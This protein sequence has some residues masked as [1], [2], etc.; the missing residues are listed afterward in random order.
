MNLFRDLAFAR[1]NAA[2]RV[3]SVAEAANYDQKPWSLLYKAIIDSLGASPSSFQLLYPFASWNWP[4]QSVG[5]I[6]AAQYDFCST[7][8]QWSAVGAYVSSGDRFNQAYEQFLNVILPTTDDPI[9]REQIRVSGEALTNAT[10]DYT[11]AVTQAE[12][13]YRDT[14]GPSNTPPFTDWLGTLQG[15]GWQTKIVAAQTRMDQAQVNYNTVVAQANTPG[16]ENA[17]TQFKNLDFYSKLTNPGLSTFPKVPSWSVSQNPGAWVDA[18]KAGHGPAGATMGFT[19][20]DSSY[21]YSKTWAGGSLAVQ[22]FFWSVNV[23]G[24][25]ERITE[26]EMDQQ[27]EVSIEFEAVDQIQIQPT[28][29]Y[30][31]SFVRSMGGGPFIKGYSAYGA[32][33]DKAVFGEKGFIGLLKTGIFVGYKPTF[34]ITTSQSSFNSFVEKF[35]VCT[36]LRIGPFTMNAEGGSEKSGWSY[37]QAGRSFSGTSTSDSPLIIGVTVARLPN[38]VDGANALAE[39]EESE[40][41]GIGYRFE[42]LAGDVLG[43]GVT[44]AEAQAL[45]AR[46][47]KPL[48]RVLAGL[49]TRHAHDVR[50]LPMYGDPVLTDGI[51]SIDFNGPALT[52]LRAGIF[53]INKPIPHVGT[54]YVVTGVYDET[55]LPFKFTLTCR[56][57]GRPQSRFS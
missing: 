25:W 16:L 43:Q 1:R 46:S 51:A 39:E 19:N 38:Q 4:T 10:N 37:S 50:V 14:V 17:H 32:D 22:E 30:N 31:G 3:P 57:A 55:N 54:Q 20:R 36:G 34:T 12:S 7:V 53:A 41:R 2:L 52:E 28:D 15:K 29:W 23:G 27:L 49:T 56:V 35:K 13:V 18:I 11:T 40:P 44:E 48:G 9:L 6:S 5:F 42:E 33:G 47:W 45:G 8:P 21:D 26:F 24:K